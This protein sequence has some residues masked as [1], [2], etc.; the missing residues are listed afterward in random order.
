MIKW[1]GFYKVLVKGLKWTFVGDS[2]QYARA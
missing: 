2:E 1:G